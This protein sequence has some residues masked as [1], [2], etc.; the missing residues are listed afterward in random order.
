MATTKTLSAYEYLSPRFHFAPVAHT[1]YTYLKYLEEAQQPG[2]MN[3]ML[4]SIMRPI[5]KTVDNNLPSLKH[6]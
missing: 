4:R 6:Y 1:T 3:A 2:R 5:T